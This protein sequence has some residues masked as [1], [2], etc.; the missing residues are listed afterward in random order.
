MPGDEPDACLGWIPG[1][2]IAC[3]GHG[4]VNGAYVFLGTDGEHR[5]TIIKGQDALQFFEILKR[6]KL[7]TPGSGD[8]ASRGA[9]TGCPRAPET[10]SP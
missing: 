5:H 9:R 4:D 1:A 7:V 3:C 10:Q 2:F 8:N 6:S